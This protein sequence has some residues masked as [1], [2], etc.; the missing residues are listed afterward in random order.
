MPLYNLLIKFINKIL[1][2][3]YCI[4]YIYIYILSYFF[5]KN[6]KSRRGPCARILK[7]HTDMQVTNMDVYTYGIKR[8]KNLTT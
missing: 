1:Y 4:L 2:I 3:I 7:I 6:Y 8:S 5:Y